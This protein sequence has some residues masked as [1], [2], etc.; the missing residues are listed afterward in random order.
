MTLAIE[1]HGDKLFLMVDYGRGHIVPIAEFL[2]PHAA[3]RFT[4]A[5]TL[6]KGAAHAHGQNGI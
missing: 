3:G 4:E 6:A 1:R 2:S 5:L